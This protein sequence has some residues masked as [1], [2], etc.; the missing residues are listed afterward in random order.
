[1]NEPKT[2]K[3]LIEVP[4]NWIDIDSPT[5]WAGRT[6]YE[7]AKRK[8]EDAIIEQYMSKITL[9]EITWSKEEVKAKIIDKLAERAL[10]STTGGAE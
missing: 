4:E 6:I 1:M 8:I 5:L 10:E 2:I 9:P 3:V 7:M